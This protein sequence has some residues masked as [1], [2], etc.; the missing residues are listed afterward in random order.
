M[1]GAPQYALAGVIAG[2][3]GGANAGIIGILVFVVAMLLL[4]K[5]TYRADVFDVL[6]GFNRWW[7]TR[8]G[9]RRFHDSAVPAVPLRRR[10]AR[11]YGSA[12]APAR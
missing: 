6:M 4:F 10:L 1:L 3:G 8:A 12:T 7:S 9:V 5:D 11:T 2:G